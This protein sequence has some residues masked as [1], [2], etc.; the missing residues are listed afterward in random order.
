MKQHIWTYG[1]GCLNNCSGHFLNEAACNTTTG[2][3]DK[4][5]KAGYMGKH[6][7]KGLKL[8]FIYVMHLY[9]LIYEI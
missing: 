2:S 8:L 7:E 6:C 1:Q 3:C 9:T 5:C 4:G